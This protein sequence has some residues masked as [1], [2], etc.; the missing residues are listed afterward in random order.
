MGK[1]VRVALII[2]AAAMVSS[3]A[4]KEAFAQG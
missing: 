4:P 3:L 1:T 2:A